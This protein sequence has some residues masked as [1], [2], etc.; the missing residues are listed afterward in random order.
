MIVFN[1]N[2]VV[3]ELAHMQADDF[4]IIQRFSLLAANLLLELD[5]GFVFLSLFHSAYILDL[6]FSLLNASETKIR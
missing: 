4:S 5:C 6:Y 1:L 2:W 3:G